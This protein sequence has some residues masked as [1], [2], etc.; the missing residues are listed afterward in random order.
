MRAALP[1]REKHLPSQFLPAAGAVPE[2]SELP[3][4]DGEQS[5]GSYFPSL[6]G[7][8]ILSLVFAVARYSTAQRGLKRL[9][10]DD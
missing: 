10:I 3:C 1:E 9:S 6:K 4:S 7:D 8:C 2:V 5:R